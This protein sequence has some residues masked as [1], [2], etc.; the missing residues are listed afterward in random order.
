MRGSN[1][2]HH[3]SS[4]QTTVALSSGEAELT[5]ICK[6]A[7]KGIGLRSLSADLG[8]TFSLAVLSDATAATCICRRRGLGRVRHISVADLSVQDKVRCR[9]FV[10]EKLKGADNMADATTQHIDAPTLSKHMLNMPLTYEEGRAASAP[11][12]TH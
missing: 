10:L 7:S 4:T 9:D 1:L 11:A 5:G 6:A 3:W 8:L 12:L 2:R